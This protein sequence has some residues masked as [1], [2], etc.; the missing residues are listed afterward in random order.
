LKA[1]SNKKQCEASSEELTILKHRLAELEI[2]QNEMKI[3]LQGCEDK[4]KMKEESKLVDLDIKDYI[5]KLSEQSADLS[6]KRKKLDLKECKLILGNIDRDIAELTSCKNKDYLIGIINAE[7]AWFE[8]NTKFYTDEL[9]KH[10]KDL[11]FFATDLELGEE[12]ETELVCKLGS[13][14]WK[15]DKKR[16]KCSPLS[17]DGLCGYELGKEDAATASS[18]ETTAR[19]KGKE[20]SADDRFIVWQEGTVLLC[21]DSKE[22]AK[23]AGGGGD[24]KANGGFRFQDAGKDS[25]NKDDDLQFKAFDYENPAVCSPCGLMSKVP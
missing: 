18:E 9:D 22:D 24:A 15:G 8:K 14:T 19:F 23:E 25:G 2:K 1:I 21:S 11:E 6:E 7:I 5:K 17:S 4:D 20:G 3:E 13:T 16:K 12:C 10:K